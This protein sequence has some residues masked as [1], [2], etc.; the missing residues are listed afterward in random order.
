MV[1]DDG[2]VRFSFLRAIGEKAA[3]KRFTLSL[4]P[5]NR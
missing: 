4:P 5:A 1:H 3:E 2:F